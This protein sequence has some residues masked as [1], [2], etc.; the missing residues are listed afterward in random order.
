MDEGPRTASIRA[1]IEAINRGD[2]D[3]VVAFCHDDVEMKRVDGIP[4]HEMVHGK[5]ALRSFL[6]PDVFSEQKIEVRRITEDGD[7]VLAHLSVRNRGAASGIDLEVESYNVYLFDG[8]LV[9]RVE[10]WR[11]LEDAE[12]SCGLRLGTGP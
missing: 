1:S 10:S 11:S 12:R 9:R 5:P 3:A 8:E 7:A 2:L 6:E 4:E